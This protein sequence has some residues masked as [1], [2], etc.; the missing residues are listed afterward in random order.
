MNVSIYRPEAGA[1]H[2]AQGIRNTILHESFAS[3]YG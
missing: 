2:T 3:I 1:Q